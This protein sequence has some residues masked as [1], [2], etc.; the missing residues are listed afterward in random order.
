MRI[1]PSELVSCTFL[2]YHSRMQ[3]RHLSHGLKCLILSLLLIA[4][5]APEWPAFGDEAYQINALVGLRQFDFLVW[6]TGAVAVKAEA[7]LANEHSYLDEASRRQIVQ[8]YL[9]LMQEIGQLEWQIEQTFVQR[10]DG[11]PAVTAVALQAELDRK[12]SEAAR[13]QPFAEAIVQDQVAAVLR[14]EGFALL[15]QTWPPVMMH[16]TPLPT[17]LIVSPRDRIERTYGIP[18]VHGVSIPEREG[19][20]TAVLTQLD[21]SALVV[22]IGG[23]GLYPSMIMETGNLNWLAEVT[24]HEWSHV[25]MSPYPISLGY[26]VDPQVRTMNETTAS[27]VGKEIGRKVVERYYPDLVLPPAAPSPD[28]TPDAPPPFDFRAEMAET[29]VQTDALLAEGKIEEA[30]AYMETRRQFFVENGYNIRKLN[31]AYFA[32]Y[33]AYADEPGAT[34]TDPV[35]PLVQEVRALSPSLK[36]FLETMAPIG[37]FEELQEAVERMKAEGWKLKDE[38]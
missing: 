24:A 9:A 5:A 38:G 20:E 4:L 30:E 29:R 8:D 7:A 10:E 17:L 32:F 31:Q 37:S 33:G 23:L 36:A 13:V 35:G 14:D 22:P 16:M 25:W 27:I 19:L 3:W 26:G 2:D 1:A 21:L 6:E 34:G 18:L 11:D 12:Q 28:P 15:G